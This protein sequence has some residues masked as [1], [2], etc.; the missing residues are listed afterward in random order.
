MENIKSYWNEI[1]KLTTER[2]VLLAKVAE[3]E[4]LLAEVNESLNDERVWL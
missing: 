2:D 3:L 4:N 1:S